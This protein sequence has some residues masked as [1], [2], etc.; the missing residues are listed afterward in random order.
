MEQ[1]RQAMVVKQQLQQQQQQG[2]FPQPPSYFTA[3]PHTIGISSREKRITVNRVYQQNGTH[4]KGSSGIKF[5]MMHNN[6]NA[7]KIGGRVA[8]TLNGR[9]TSIDGA[10]TT[11]RKF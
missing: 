9:R 3:R 6:D 7:N 11:V 1:K 5:L 4:M 10:S 8:L 2:H